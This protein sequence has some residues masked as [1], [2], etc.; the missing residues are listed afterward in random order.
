[1]TGQVYPAW[2]RG[3]S[4]GPHFLLVVVGAVML[5]VVRGDD[6]GLASDLGREAGIQ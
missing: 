1:M 5:S 2:P 6:R 3:L 4:V